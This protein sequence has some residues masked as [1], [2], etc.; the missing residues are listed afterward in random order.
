MRSA[1]QK[2]WQEEENGLKIS[3]SGNAFLQEVKWEAHIIQAPETQVRDRP[4]VSPKH[5]GIPASEKLIFYTICF[6]RLIISE[7][8]L[9]KTHMSNTYRAG[10]QRAFPSL[11]PPYLVASHE[12]LWLYP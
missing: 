10:A 2:Q 5:L 12:Y 3:N 1:Q 11:P 9:A 6:S 8:Q 7:P 4:H